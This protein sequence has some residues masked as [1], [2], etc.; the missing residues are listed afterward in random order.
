MAWFPIADSPTANPSI[1]KASITRDWALLAAQGFDVSLLEQVRSLHREPLVAADQQ[2]FYGMLRAAS[3][4]A[5]EPTPAPVEADAADL[6]RGRRNRWAATCV[7]T[8]NRCD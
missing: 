4:L 8:A 2:A 3:S 6:L 1:A 7:W 5:A